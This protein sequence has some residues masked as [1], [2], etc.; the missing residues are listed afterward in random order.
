MK[1]WLNN[2]FDEHGF[3]IGCLACIFV[4]VIALAFAFGVLCLEGWLL[5]LLWNAV[6]PCIFIGAPTLQFWWAVGLMLIC[7]ILFKSSSGFKNN[8]D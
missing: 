6:I 7:S 8:K 3:A 2:T 1:K 5:M 4:I